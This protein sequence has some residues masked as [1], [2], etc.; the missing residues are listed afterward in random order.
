VR[1]VV[2]VWLAA[3]TLLLAACSRVEEQPPAEQRSE[4]PKDTPWAAMIEPVPVPAT[5][6]SAQPHLSSSSRGLILSWLEHRDTT[7]TL[8]FAERVSGAWSPARTVE[9][10]DKWFISGADVPS[11]M[12]LSDGT[13]VATAYPATDPLIEAYD[14]RLTY[15]RDD[16]KTWARAIA[17]HHDGTMTQHGFATLF[18]MPGRAL[19]VVWLDG[20]DQEL[21]KTDPAGGAM[22]LYF[23]SFDRD[24]KQ[25]AEEVVNTRVCECCQTTAAMTDEGPVVAF[26]DRSPREVRDIHVTRLADGKWTQPRPLHVDGWLI[27]ACPVNGPA[28]TARGRA[29]AAAWFAASEE[30]GHAYAAFSSDAGRTWSDPIRLDD[31]VALGHVDIELLDDGAAVASWVEFVNQRAQLRVRRIEASG[32][33]SAAHIVAGTGDGYVAGYPRLARHGDELMLAWTEST[34]DAVSGQQVKAARVR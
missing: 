31:A 26:R 18:E 14:L 16:G 33:R 6:Q 13:L 8:K 2:T 11:V 24:W 15:S 20:R 30:E 19:G 21:N 23:A 28:L 25:T 27:E 5:G 34:A 22:G 1:Y 17:P 9:S 29:V 10:S 32:G 7:A 3:A 12:R 4:A